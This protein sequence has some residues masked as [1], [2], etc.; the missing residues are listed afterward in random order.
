MTTSTID[1][2]ALAESL[3]DDGGR[4]AYIGQMPASVL[5]NG[6]LDRDTIDRWQTWEEECIQ[7]LANAASGDA[8]SLRRC[9][10]RG[11]RRRVATWRDDPLEQTCHQLIARA[12]G[13]V[14][15]V[16]P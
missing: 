10:P 9:L 15:E 7:V 13:R 14:E 3:V 1:L 8:S 4:F 12:A 11:L 16:S 6:E 5:F 2:R